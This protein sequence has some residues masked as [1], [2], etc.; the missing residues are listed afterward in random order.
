MKGNRVVIPKALIPETLS[1][2]HDGHQGLSATLQRARGTVY[3]PNM[4]QDI[5]EVIWKC[6]EF[7][8]SNTR[9]Q[10]AKI[11]RKTDSNHKTHGNDES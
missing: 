10:E 11:Y 4:Q 8:L 6:S 1:R 3:W 9:Y 2:L 7:R 5:G